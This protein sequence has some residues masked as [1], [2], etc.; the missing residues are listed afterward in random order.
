VAE[1]LVLE[2]PA[3][4]VIRRRRLVP[5]FA[6]NWAIWLSG[7]I[8]AILVLVAIFAPVLAP[9][10]PTDVS[11]TNSLQGPSAEHPLGTDGSGRDI[12]SRLIEG[13]R[14]SLAGPALVVLFSALIAIPL[15]LIAGY[16]GGWA[17]SLL[18]RTWDVMFAFPPLLLAIVIVAA[19]GAGF[20]AATIAITITYVPLLA[21]V[22]RAQVLVEREKAYVDAGRVQGFS[23]SRLAG[24][25]I[26]PNIAP[27]IVAQATLNF[28]YALIDLAGLAFLG[29]GVQE[30]NAD[31][32]AMLAQGRKFILSS[33]AELIYASIAIS[34]AVVAFNVLGDA[35]SQRLGRRR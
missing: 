10:D 8:I 30:P 16:R 26:L 33:P 5:T 22:V 32:G 34:V 28:G 11:L 31:W 23:G 12:L 27:T 21:R 9:H 19:F 24:R 7:S 25:H 15:G 4:S 35:L 29:L 17:D 2:S 6:G 1:P 14:L 20:W 13:T 18:S 3:P